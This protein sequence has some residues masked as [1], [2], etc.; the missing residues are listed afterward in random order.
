MES[1]TGVNG[2]QHGPEVVVSG[3]RRQSVDRRRGS[4]TKR[5]AMGKAG[6]GGEETAYRDMAGRFLS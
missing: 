5:D 2:A 4:P 6:F 1:T 3:G